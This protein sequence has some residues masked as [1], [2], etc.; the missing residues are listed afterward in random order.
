[1]AGIDTRF[2]K[3][4][5]GQEQE[6][7]LGLNAVLS[8]TREKGPCSNNPYFNTVVKLVGDVN[9]CVQAACDQINFDSAKTIKKLVDAKLPGHVLDSAVR[10]EDQRVKQAVE[11]VQAMSPSDVAMAM[12]SSVTNGGQYGGLFETVAERAPNTAAPKRKAGKSMSSGMM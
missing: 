11:A 10:Y 4:D 8:D 5:N 12:I 3:S 2:T 9:G 6:D 7:T 1:M